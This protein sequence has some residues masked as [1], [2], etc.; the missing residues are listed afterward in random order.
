LPPTGNV[1]KKVGR[2]SGKSYMW[3]RSITRLRAQSKGIILRWSDTPSS[4]TLELPVEIVNEDDYEPIIRAPLKVGEE[5]PVT[6]LSKDYMVNGIVRFCRADKNSF[7]ITVST[8][9]TP[10]EQLNASFFRDP[11]ALVIDDFLTEEEE[12][13]ILQSL[14]DPPPSRR[15]ETSDSSLLRDSLSSLRLLKMGLLLLTGTVKEP[16][17]CSPAI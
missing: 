15:E 16:L 10:E 13:K 8:A 5:T 9:G 2:E 14:Q 12:A 17:C 11:G 4:P 3:T 6:L 7:L 1:D